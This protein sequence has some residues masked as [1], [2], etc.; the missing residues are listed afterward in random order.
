MQMNYL[1][2]I[3]SGLLIIPVL[4][5]CS[6]G[7]AS[8]DKNIV[9]LHTNDVHCFIEEN[10]GYDGLAAYKKQMLADGNEVILVDAGDHCQGA[11]VGSLSKGAYPIEIMNYVGYDLAIPGNH[12]FDYSADTFLENAKL[13]KY[14]YISSTFLRVDN[15]RVFNATKIIEK[16]GVKIGFVGIS[17]PET[18]GNG[19]PANFQDDKG[20]YKYTFMESVPIADYYKN[21]Q[22]SIDSLKQS[23][24]NYIIALAHL[25][26][27]G[28]YSSSNLVKNVSGL[29]LVIDAHS[30]TVVESLREKDKDGNYVTI[31]QTGTVLNNIGKVVINKKGNISSGLVNMAVATEKDADTTAFIKTIKDRYEK[32]I[33]KKIG[34]SNFGLTIYDSDTKERLIRK[35]CTNMGDIFADALKTFGQSDIGYSNAG[36]IRT[37]IEAGDIT[38]KDVMTV[39]P[40]GNSFTIIRISGKVLKDCIENGA[41]LSP[42]EN[43][44]LFIPSGV[45]YTIDTS[46]PSSV[47]VDENGS[48]VSVT[49]AYR[50]KDIKVNGETLD[51]N[52]KYTVSGT[53]YNLINCGDALSLFKNAEII[54]RDTTLEYEVL[55]SYIRDN[56]KGEIPDTYKD[57]QGQGRIKII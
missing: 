25:G 37:D 14:E 41:R 4:A 55:A 45:T 29:D 17:T 38:Y 32:E 2:R 26:V 54:K 20:N 7:T 40:F 49:G 19:F 47:Q 9:I 50:V 57:Q 3:I 44:S 39:V 1:M 34:H 35:K 8:K 30:H 5:S 42:E 46:V 31:T 13:A 48:F 18:I 24:V 27:E 10:I 33:L 12:E 53:S 43:G 21:I 16:A 15:T 52:K 28:N 56:L 23:N 36:A 22:D 6:S 11:P 51:E